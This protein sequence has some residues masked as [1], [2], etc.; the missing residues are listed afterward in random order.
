MS[1]RAALYR[2]RFWIVGF[3]V[4]EV[5][6]VSMV[7]PIRQESGYYVYDVPDT[8][9]FSGCGFVTLWCQQGSCP[10]G[11]ENGTGSPGIYNPSPS[12]MD[13]NIF[14]WQIGVGGTLTCL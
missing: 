8:S 13:Y 10:L 3:F 12:T 7:A 9:L 14:G 4:L 11:V 2:N 1:V 5:A 6:L